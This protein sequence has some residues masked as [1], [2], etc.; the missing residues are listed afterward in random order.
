MER[1][2][3]TRVG[4]LPWGLKVCLEI[5]SAETTTQG[6]QVCLQV[7]NE[8]W[9]SAC[10]RKYRAGRAAGHLP[11]QAHRHIDE[12][13]AGVK[14]TPEERNECCEKDSSWCTQTH[15]RCLE[16]NCDLVCS[17]ADF[18]FLKVVYPWIQSSWQGTL[19]LGASSLSRILQFGHSRPLTLLPTWAGELGGPGKCW[20]HQ[21]LRTHRG[22][23][24]TPRGGSPLPD[25]GSHAG[26]CASL[27]SSL[28]DSVAWHTVS[29]TSTWR[30]RAVHPDP[31]GES[32]CE[33][34]ATLKLT[35]AHSREDRDLFA[36]PT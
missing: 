4:D 7:C 19:E 12:L 32:C 5:L 13:M 10:R 15:K 34:M 35:S 30:L 18:W 28:C 31:K 27:G 16:L 25:A 26:T 17:A 33:R 22:Q 2:R 8:V 9:R 23:E 24:P 29:W 1:A 11:S 3:E 36:R 6:Q 20:A 14:A 21:G